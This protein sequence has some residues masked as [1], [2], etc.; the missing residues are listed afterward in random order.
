MSYLAIPFLGAF[1]H[2]CEWIYISRI[3]KIGNFFVTPIM[4]YVFSAKK[5]DLRKVKLWNR[6]SKCSCPILDLRNRLTLLHMCTMFLILKRVDLKIDWIYC[7]MF[8]ILKMVD[9]KIDWL[10]CTMFLLK[11]VDLILSEHF[12]RLKLTLYALFNAGYHLISMALF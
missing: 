1:L 7:T 8:L 11:M 12:S 10:Y 2:Q 4:T 6:T 3:S 9:L 5:S